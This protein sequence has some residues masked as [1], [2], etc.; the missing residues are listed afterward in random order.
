MIPI[1]VIGGIVAAVTL[2]AKGSSAPA[3]PAAGLAPVGSITSPQPSTPT[4]T[5]F[6]TPAAEALYNSA[7]AARAA[8]GIPIQLAPPAGYS[9][10]RP[11][12]PAPKVNPIAIVRPPLPVVA[13]IYTPSELSSGASTGWARPKISLL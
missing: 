8:A 4:P 1:L 5:I 10:A 12:P 2:L 6:D 7:V 3:A 11:A 13:R 9:Y